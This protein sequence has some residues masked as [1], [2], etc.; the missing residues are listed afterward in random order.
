MQAITETE[1]KTEALAAFVEQLI[2]GRN[3]DTRQPNKAELTSTT[4]VYVPLNEASAKIRTGD[5]STD[6]QMSVQT[7]FTELQ[8]C[9][10][11]DYHH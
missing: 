11:N 6:T 1:E 2:P 9:C 8:C 7:S 3:A 4:I 5:I 10:F